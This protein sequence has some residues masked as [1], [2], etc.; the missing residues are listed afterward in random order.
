[1]GPNQDLC[2]PF[3]LEQFRGRPHLLLRNI[4]VQTSTGF[5]PRYKISKE[6]VHLDNGGVD[7]ITTFDNL[8]NNMLLLSMQRAF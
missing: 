5:S 6:Y 7:D 3:E 1:M 2:E 8:I 4:Q